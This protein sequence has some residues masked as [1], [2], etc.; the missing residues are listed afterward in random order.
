MGIRVL[1]VA[2]AIGSLVLTA[3]FA[4][5]CGGSSGGSG[6]GSSSGGSGGSGGN[7]GG[8]G[9]GNSSSS[10]GV[11]GFGDASAG[12]GGGVC[13]P[14][15]ANYD[16][17]GNNCDDDG[18]GKVDN[19]PTCDGSLML[20]G[21]AHDFANAL[22]L[23]QDAAGQKWGIVSAT[24]TKGFG[25]GGAPNDGQHGIL[26]HFGTA[27]MPREGTNLGVLSSGYAREW[28]NTSGTGSGS[29]PNPLMSA[30][31]APCFKGNQTPMDGMIPGQAPPGYPKA[32]AA[33]PSQQGIGIFDTISVTLQIKTP[34]NAQGLQFDFNFY[35]GEWPE[36][37]CTNYN[38]S[39]V[40]W[41]QSAAFTGKNGDLNISYD[42][43]NDPVSVNNAF[44]ETCT[45][46]ASTG[47]CA[48]QTQ[49]G[50]GS[51][52]GTATCTSGP[53]ELAGTGFEDDGTYCG[54]ASTGG[55]ATG[56][57]TTTAPVKAGEV[58]T[59]QFII[60]DTGD[61]NYDSSVLVDHFTWQ[62]GPT[63]TGTQPAQ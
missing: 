31:G 59:I 8:S 36:W 43:K 15:P 32:A 52:T 2:G 12:E 50:C 25:G 6:F 22:G 56:W 10:G 26:P 39:F 3:G 47:C 38:D 35:S 19:T 30:S 28:D 29:C 42:S 17:P 63:M 45:S 21:T 13:A 9:G 61:Y 40:A 37:V 24:Y 1:C 44:F 53:G 14:N 62:P 27:V 33:C 34:A 41:L 11:I 46:N 49:T 57:L 5:G 60:W 16:I 51:P 48:M 23:C 54:G 7:S 58:I 20:T 55:G 4:P 18:D